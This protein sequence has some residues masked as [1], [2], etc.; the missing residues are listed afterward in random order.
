V[1]EYVDQ[2][3]EHFLDP[4]VIRDHHY[5]APSAPGYSIQMADESLRAYQFPAGNAGPG[6]GDRSSTR[7]TALFELRL[8]GNPIR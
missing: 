1:L 7:V 2:L 6:E 4:V 8:A 5:L 3:H